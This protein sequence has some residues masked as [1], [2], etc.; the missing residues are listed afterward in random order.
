MVWFWIR[1]PGGLINWWN[2]RISPE[3]PPFYQN[4]WDGA[5][6]RATQFHHLIHL[7]HDNILIEVEASLQ[8][9][10]PR[11][12][13]SNNWDANHQWWIPNEMAWNPLWIRFMGKWADGAHRF[14]TLKKIAALFPEVTTLH[15]SV[16]EPGATLV[17]HQGPFKGVNRYHY[18][19]KVA[20][21]DNGL[22]IGSQNFKWEAKEGFIWDDTLPHSA[23]NHTDTQ[24]L[25]IFG[26]IFR[27]LSTLNSY[28]SR[29]IYTLLQQTAPV[30][31][32]Q[33][34]LLTVDGISDSR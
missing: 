2:T 3:A 16:F 19:L 14:P 34:Q 6:P 31:E 33:S 28:G 17:E 9:S 8:D 32:L 10:K 26:D 27:P 1:N 13:I 7:N 30:I 11:A 20:P 24:R 4:A 12:A 18:G 15:I 21:N 29:L 25:V 22:K 5:N 23:W